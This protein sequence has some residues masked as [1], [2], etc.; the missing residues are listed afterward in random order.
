M[1][2]P[3]VKLIVEYLLYANNL[4]ETSFTI[5]NLAGGKYTVK[6][7]YPFPAPILVVEEAK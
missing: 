6:Y 7:P 3:V 4:V 2:K 1:N 5:R